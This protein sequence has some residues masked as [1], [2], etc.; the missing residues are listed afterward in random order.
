MEKSSNLR[1]RGI[2]LA[3]AGPLL[4]GFSGIAA[5]YLFTV[6]QVSP[7]WLVGIRMLGAGVLG[8]CC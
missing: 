8:C 4:W 2:I 1:Q 6:D 3:I 7:Q 5:Q